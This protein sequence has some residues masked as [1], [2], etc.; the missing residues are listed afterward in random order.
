MEKPADTL[1]PIHDLLK[2]RWSPLA[3]SDRMVEPEKLQSV[4]EAARWAPSSFN[5]QPWRFILCT[6]EQPEAHR[7]MVSCLAEG[8]VPWASRAPVLML[9]IARRTF[10][11]NGKPNR[12][13]PYDVGAAVG[14]AIMEAT[15]LGL[16]V[17]QMAGF[18]V[19]KARSLFGIPEDY[20]PM[21]V[22]AVG[23]MGSPDDLPPALRQRHLAQRSRKPIGTIVFDGRWDAPSAL[24]SKA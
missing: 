14:L 2:L 12:H 22:V 16:V 21:A 23:Y 17:H 8:N 9:S 13:A 1:Y 24:V 11:H 15:H 10:T 5:E 4:L 3:F 6:K 18:D 7:R 19:E 20:D